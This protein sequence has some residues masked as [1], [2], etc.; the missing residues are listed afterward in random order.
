[1]PPKKGQRQ[2]R[3]LVRQD[4]I[5]DAAYELFAGEG[6]RTTTIAATVRPLSKPRRTCA[7]AMV[8]T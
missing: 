1:M 8:A 5:L 2:A 6:V 3:G 4:R 7:T